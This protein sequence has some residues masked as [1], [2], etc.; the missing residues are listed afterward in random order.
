MWS[1]RIILILVLAHVTIQSTNK[2]R[3]GRLLSLFN[4]VQFANEGC[5]SNSAVSG[6]SVSGRL[7]D[8]TCFTADECAK[9]QGQSA[10]TCASGF[11]VCCIFSSMETGSTISQNC[12]YIRNPG[13]PMP[14]EA[15][16]SISHTI[17][18]SSS[19]VCL[20][21]L[22]FEAFTIQGTGNQFETNTLVTPPTTGGVCLDQFTIQL[23]SGITIPTIC[24]QN[25]GE[26][27]YLDVGSTGSS[28]AELSFTFENIVSNSRQWEIKVIQIPCVSSSR[29]P[30]GCLQFHEGSSGR[31]ISFNFLDSADNHLASQDYSICV[32]QEA[33]FC[34]VEYFP[35]SDPNSF[36][37]DT[38][39]VGASVGGACVK[40]HIGIEGAMTVC[41]SGLE[42]NKFC[43]TALNTAPTLTASGSVCDC[44]APFGVRIVTDG[45]VDVGTVNVLQSRGVCLE[46]RQRKC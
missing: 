40:D 29:V 12:T 3:N 13:F 10:G 7:R 18:K 24:G 38:S 4:I 41:G 22:D 34:C 36:S 8:G 42:T 9:K 37:L 23:T 20:L 25:S 1:L 35:C 31:M 16:D 15:T 19:D 2:T 17:Q 39:I 26:H 46:Y 43:G 30:Q 32:R 27:M 14:Y 44:S 6:G 28:T 45:A 11:G 33:G 5:T 21:R